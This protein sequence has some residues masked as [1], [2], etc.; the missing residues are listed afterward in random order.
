[1]GIIFALLLPLTSCDKENI[2]LD[3]E[4]YDFRWST[5]RSLSSDSVDF[6]IDLVAKTVAKAQGSVKVRSFLLD[7]I[8]E[9]GNNLE[10]GLLAHLVRKDIDGVNFAS[11]LSNFSQQAGVYRD[12][13]FFAKDLL[14]LIPNLTISF[15]TDDVDISVWEWPSNA[16][17]LPVLPVVETFYDTIPGNY[18]AYDFNLDTTSFS[19]TEDPNTSVLIIQA[20]PDIIPIDINLLI[21]LGGSGLYAE[22]TDECE[23][24]EE[25]IEKAALGIGNLD[26]IIMVDGQ[27]R[28]NPE[29]NIALF[30]LNALIEEY[31]RECADDDDP[32]PPPPP[33]P[34][35][36]CDRD[37]RECREVITQWR[38]TNGLIDVKPFCHWTRGQCQIRVYTRKFFRNSQGALTVEEKPNRFLIGVRREMRKKQIIT[39]NLHMYRY[40]YLEDFHSDFYYYTFTGIHPRAGNSRTFGFT[41]GGTYKFNDDIQINAS[42]N[43]SFTKTHR[44]YEL[45]GDEIYYCDP[46]NGLGTKYSTGRFEFW[47][48]ED[49][50]CGN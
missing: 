44:D 29:F 30:N 1:M 10:T 11:V 26:L 17:L 48:K 42:V 41:L 50:T 13:V 49:E 14:F 18:I 28:I 47:V 3:K 36:D 21:Q 5:N 27:I 46:A 43:L 34:P 22:I 40:R 7:H 45:G 20:D 35:F 31:N 8:N 12:S 23:E 9:E 32:P 15:Y 37:S 16:T 39:S 2:N 4:E 25:A 6:Y 19:N 38:M 33:P 24:L